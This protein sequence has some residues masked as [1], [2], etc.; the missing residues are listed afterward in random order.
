MIAVRKSRA[1]PASEV[2]Q[3]TK[4]SHAWPDCALL[5]EQTGLPKRL[6]LQLATAI[7]ALT[8]SAA[9]LTYKS[10]PPTTTNATLP[11]SSQFALLPGRPEEIEA[12][13]G[14]ARSILPANAAR[15]ANRRIPFAAGGLVPA[16]PFAFVGSNEDRTRALECLA[17]AVLYEAGHDLSGQGAVAQ[18]VLNRVRHAA[19]PSTVCGVVYQGSHRSTGCQF[20]FTCDGS[21]R[22]RMP[23][24]AWQQARRVASDALGGWVY[25]RVGLATHYH[26]DWVHPYWSAKLRK[27]AQVGTHLFFGWP[28]TWGGPGA[29]PRV[30]QGQETKLPIEPPQ[31]D[32]GPSVER[33]ETATFTKPGQVSAD[34]GAP[35]P[36]YG[37]RLQVVGS[38]GQSFGLVAAPGA[39]ASQLVNAALALCPGAGYCR[40]NA[41]ARA[42]DVPATL[43]G[44]AGSHRS[45]IFEYLRDPALGASTVRFDCARFATRNQR[46]CL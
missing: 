21:L 37:A 39:S 19:F 46:L 33:A 35:V 16:K 43:S 5:Q 20:T 30:Y 29:F 44:A 22:R 34:L 14:L 36:L 40:V 28:G 13:G 15:L 12:R 18:V 25:H 11:Q 6:G 45:F 7:L 8:P 1:G 2:R 42:G 23:D 31:A 38:G 4:L 24:Y 41:W 10:P 17:T 32:E 26:T 27:L 3:G 9:A